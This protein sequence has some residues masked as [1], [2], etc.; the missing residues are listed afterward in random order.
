MFYL[1]MSD[2]DLHLRRLLSSDKFTL[3]VLCS[4]IISRVTNKLVR[5]FKFRDHKVQVTNPLVINFP[6]A[7]NEPINTAFLPL[8]RK[9][10]TILLTQ[11]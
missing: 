1:I 5:A 6:M 8:H 2:F 4:L 9:A 10:P 3:F 11:N 7:F